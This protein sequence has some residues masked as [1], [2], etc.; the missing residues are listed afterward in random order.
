MTSGTSRIYTEETGFHLSFFW[1]WHMLGI[2]QHS[3][4]RP[5]KLYYSV[6]GCRFV[7][8]IMYI[9]KF[10]VHSDLIHYKFVY[11][12]WHFRDKSITNIEVIV[13]NNKMLLTQ[14]YNW[15]LNIDNKNSFKILQILRFRWNN[16]HHQKLDYF[17]K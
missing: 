16:Q 3:R 14:R 17:W 8:F 4:P 6:I 7:T 12:G 2:D 10:R 13:E 11:T 1:I 15:F 9:I 5:Y